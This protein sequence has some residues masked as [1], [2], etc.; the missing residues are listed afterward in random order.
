MNVFH[1]DKKYYTNL[2]DMFRSDAIDLDKLTD[3]WFNIIS[4]E[5]TPILFRG[6]RIFITDGVKKPK[7]GRRMP[8]VK[9]LHS[10]SDT[11]SKPSS[12][13]GIQAAGIVTLVR[14][15][16][17]Q[18]ESLSM[19]VEIRLMDGLKSISE[20]D[21]TSHPYAK[22]PLEMQSFH[23]MERYIS[24]TGDAYIIADRASMSQELF[25]ESENISQ[26]TGH[27]VHMITNAKSNAV[28]YE[29]PVYSGR[30]RP[31]KRGHKVELNRLFSDRA[32]DFRR[33]RLCIYGRHQTVRYLSVSLRWGIRHRIPLK[34]VLCLMEDGRR[35]IL[36]TNDKNLP[37]TDVIWLYAQRFGSIEEDYRVLKTEFGGMNYRFW[38]HEMPHLSHF[39]SSSEPDILE[40][41]KTADDRRLVLRAIRASE[42]YMQTA[43]IAMGFVK[44]LAA[45]QQPG[46][47]IQMFT[48]KR[49]YTQRKVSE[50]DVCAFLRLHQDAVFHKYRHSFLINFITEH[51][52]MDECLKEVI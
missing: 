12:F 14:H 13:H 32:D 41:V 28:A 18:A 50:A 23:R 17:N 38:T 51:Q 21:G 31:P 15:P 46:G 22:E 33:A 37:G 6:R 26:R 35:I 9:R 19:P 1:L 34:F 52:H 47:P 25:L 20:W 29:E 3:N 30:G 36:A 7:E 27:K 5:C 42:L 48:Q 44:L 45:K 49:T 8:G 10:D 43:F 11:Q 2:D 16:G 4:N 24:Q 39:R 40:E